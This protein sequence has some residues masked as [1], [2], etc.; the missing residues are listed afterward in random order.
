M[1]AQPASTQ[2]VS[3]AGVRSPIRFLVLWFLLPLAL[4]LLADGLG[5]PVWIQEFVNRLLF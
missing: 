3:T 4:L 5:L 1:M 2:P